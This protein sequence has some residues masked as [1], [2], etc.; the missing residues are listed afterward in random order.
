VAE[1]LCCHHCQ[2]DDGTWRGRIE[3]VV[4]ENALSDFE[5]RVQGFNVGKGRD[6]GGTFSEACVALNLCF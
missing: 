4:I 5:F 6:R 3:F 2:Y 1:F